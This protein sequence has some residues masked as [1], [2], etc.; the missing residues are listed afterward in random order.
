VAERTARCRR[1]VET[2][3]KENGEDMERGFGI[4]PKAV[5]WIQ[6]DERL[7]KYISKTVLLRKDVGE[8]PC[9]T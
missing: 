1:A 9:S 6:R 2:V 3:V 7:P 8:G 5:H 4:N